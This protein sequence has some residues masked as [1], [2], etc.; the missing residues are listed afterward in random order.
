MFLEVFFESGLEELKNSISEYV[1]GMER[2]P[3]VRRYGY[4]EEDAGLWMMTDPTCSRYVGDAA[5]LY[6]EGYTEGMFSRQEV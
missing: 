2:Q 3:L 1:D 4:V 6:R 5:A